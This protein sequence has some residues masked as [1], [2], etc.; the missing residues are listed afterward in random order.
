MSAIATGKKVAFIMV[1][2]YLGYRVIGGIGLQM[3]KS[4]NTTVAKLGNVI[5]G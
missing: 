4:T 2:G 1:L 5:T 3:A